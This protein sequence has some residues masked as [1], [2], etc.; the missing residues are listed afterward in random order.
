MS[1]PGTRGGGKRWASGFE[2]VIS[3]PTQALIGEAGPEYVSVQPLNG[4]MTMPRFNSAPAMAMAGSGGGG[5]T[6]TLHL[7][8]PLISTTGVSTHDLAAAG[9]SLVAIINTQLRRVGRK[10]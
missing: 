1:E 4:G 3:Q 5:A 2:G 10:I 9:E 6:V 8:G 7:N